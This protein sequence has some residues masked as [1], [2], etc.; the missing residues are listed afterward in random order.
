MTKV[1]ELIVKPQDGYSPERLV[2]L[3][4]LNKREWSFALIGTVLAVGGL[5]A[6]KLATR[7]RN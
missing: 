3:Q 1:W 2:E 4:K 7:L 5:L 6:Y